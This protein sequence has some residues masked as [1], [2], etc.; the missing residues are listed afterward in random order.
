MGVGTLSVVSNSDDNR[1]GH[2]MKDLY[3]CRRDSEVSS[4]VSESED[5][6][7]T[8]ENDCG[9]N[10]G[11]D[12]KKSYLPSHLIT[13]PRLRRG[14]DDLDFDDTDTVDLF[15]QLDVYDRILLKIPS[16]LYLKIPDCHKTV[17]SSQ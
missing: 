14:N 10:E 17:I 4:G 7:K 1:S 3:H 9:D 12:D 16:S 11:T 15:D 2:S 5:E 6:I 8:E 13:P